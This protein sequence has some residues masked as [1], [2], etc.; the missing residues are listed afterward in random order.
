MNGEQSYGQLFYPP[1]HYSSI[2]VCFRRP[3]PGFVGGQFDQA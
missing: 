3:I 2:Y 1:Y